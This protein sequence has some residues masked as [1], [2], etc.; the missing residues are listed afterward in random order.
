MFIKHV[1]IPEISDEN[2]LV[3]VCAFSKNI[4]LKAVIKTFNRIM[5]PFRTIISFIFILGA[6]AS[7]YNM[8]S[9]YVGNLMSVAPIDV[10]HD[11]NKPG[12]HY[13]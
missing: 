9:K 1:G 3:F 2:K 8:W 6:K 11:F 7:L 12:M 5:F 10:V 13:I 4:G